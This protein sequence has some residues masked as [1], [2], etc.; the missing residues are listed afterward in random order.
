MKEI[1]DHII[2]SEVVLE[3]MAESVL[4]TTTDLNAPGPHVIYVNSAFEKMTGWNREEIIGKS[5]RILQG[6]K[7][8]H[9]I[10]NDL[11][12][13][14][15]NGKFWSGRTINY[16]KDGSEFYMQ[17]SIVPI[18]NEN[19]SIYQFMAVQKDVTTIVHTENKLHAAVEL[20]RKRLK[21]IEKTN[22]TLNKLIVTQN[23]TLIKKD[24]CNLLF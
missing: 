23:K 20:D 4:I 7:T 18:K 21:E 14:L 5:P 19:G 24:L 17:W 11:K 8:K 6:P 10:F 12:E 13:K 22:R 16:R 9:S 2:N 1:S 3:S 15:R